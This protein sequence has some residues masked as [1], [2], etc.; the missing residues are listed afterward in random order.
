MIDA[1]EVASIVLFM[2]VCISP[3]MFVLLAI[4]YFK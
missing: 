1:R 3:I 2:A 4:I